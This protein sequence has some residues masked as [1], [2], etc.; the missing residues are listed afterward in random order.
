MGDI[1]LIQKMTKDDVKDV[2]DL[3]KTFFSLSSDES[4]LSTLNSDT[5]SYYLYSLLKILC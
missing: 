4:I 1:F 5:L 3:E 2:F